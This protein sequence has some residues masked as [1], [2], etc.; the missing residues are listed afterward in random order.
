[1]ATP[2]YFGSLYPQVFTASAK[3]KKQREMG[4]SYR[5]TFS[6]LTEIEYPEGRY[7]IFTGYLLDYPVTVVS[8]YAPN[9]TSTT[10]LSHLLQVVETHKMGTL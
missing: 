2:K 10:F 4:A 3:T 7:L 5:T 1:M 9:K 6:L 8:Y